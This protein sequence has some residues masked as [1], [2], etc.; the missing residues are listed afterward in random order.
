MFKIRNLKLYITINTY[1]LYYTVYT[2]MHLY[3]GI[4]YKVTKKIILKI[5]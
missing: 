1:I 2:I 5:L 3:K 4:R